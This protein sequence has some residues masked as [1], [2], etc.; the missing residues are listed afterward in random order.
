MATKDV[1]RYKE[2]QLGQLRA[3][4]ACVRHQSFS[5][6]ARALQVSQPAVWQQVRALERHFG[7]GLLHR[8]GRELQPSEEGRVLLELAASILGSVDSLQEAFTQR[9]R[10]MPRELVVIGSPGVIAEELARPVVE[11]CR[12]HPKIR[13]TLLNYAGL[14]TLDLLLADEADFAVLPLASE[15]VGHRQL[16]VAETLCER[17][18]VLIT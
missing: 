4:C 10:D 9:C 6:A 13:L 7:V 2:L 12:R 11:F 3:F 14:R 17:P 15:V 1:Q 5:A 8:Q 18:W 16:L